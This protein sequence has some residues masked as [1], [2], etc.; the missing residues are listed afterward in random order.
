M[1]LLGT[2]TV[3]QDSEPVLTSQLKDLGTN[4]TIVASEPVLPSSKF[5]NK[6]QISNAS[7][8]ITLNDRSITCV[9]QPIKILNS[10]I[11]CSKANSFY[12]DF[13]HPT[14]LHHKPTCIMGVILP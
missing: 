10:N 6:M 3:C 14:G 4:I 1:L 2:L 8:V 5:D 11:P 9:I 7:I 13:D 12:L